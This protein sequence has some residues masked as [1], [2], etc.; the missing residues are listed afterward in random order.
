MQ[1]VASGG[2]LNRHVAGNVL[3]AVW[4]KVVAETRVGT[5]TAEGD[6]RLVLEGEWSQVTNSVAGGCELSRGAC[7][8]AQICLM[9]L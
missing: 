1:H 7:C 8:G 9:R 2:L 5:K 3:I 4:D 6:W